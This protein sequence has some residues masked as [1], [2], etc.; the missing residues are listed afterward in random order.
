M[1][2]L[3]RARALPPL[4]SMNQISLRTPS[5]SSGDGA[6]L[7]AIRVPSGESLYSITEKLPLVICI[8]SPVDT[9]IFQR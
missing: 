6:S 8:S 1:V 3:V 2:L 4:A 9:L 5:S 7:T